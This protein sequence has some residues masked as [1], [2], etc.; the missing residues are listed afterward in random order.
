MVIFLFIAALTAGAQC[1]QTSIYRHVF[2]GVVPGKDTVYSTVDVQL[3]TCTH[4]DTSVANT[5]NRAVQ[6]YIIDRLGGTAP[7]LL[8][9]CVTFERECKQAWEEP[10]SGGCDFYGSST[11]IYRDGQLV[12]MEVD[13][14]V[15][16]G[17]AHP[18]HNFTIYCFD[19]V[20][21]KE[22]SWSEWIADTTAFKSIAE[23]HFW[24]T[25]KEEFDD[26]LQP[27]DF[28]WGNDFFLPTNIGRV[29]DGVMIIYNEYEALPYVYGPV[30]ITI[31][32]DEIRSL[33]RSP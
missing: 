19:A 33:L 22:L 7:D 8:E 11:E 6:Q 15:F 31:P 4:P 16:T 20:S 32:L 29:D 26:T 24:D 12:C 1:I 5:I 14:E 30:F 13:D 18:S 25:A 10:F 23:K 21:G 27:D 28:F 2:I 9:A 3:G 17:G